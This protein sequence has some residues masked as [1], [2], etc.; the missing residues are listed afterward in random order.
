MM[1]YDCLGAYKNKKIYVIP[2]KEFLFEIDEQERMLTDIIWMISEDRRLIHNGMVIGQV[3]PN[4]KSV[5]D[6]RP[7]HY[8]IVYGTAIRSNKPQVTETAKQSQ[9]LI[10]ERVTV[11][12]LFAQGEKKL[13]AL[14]R[15]SEESLVNYES[16]GEIRL[17]R[18]VNEGKEK[19]KK[20]GKRKVGG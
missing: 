17:Q 4:L 7:L 9:T 12:A 19:A 2:K 11:E 16:D 15:E 14:I 1:T 3:T 6:L 18:L 5:E 13:M 8:S 10:S 20:Y